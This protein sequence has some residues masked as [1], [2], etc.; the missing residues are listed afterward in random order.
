MG[1][2][3]WSQLVYT[4]FCE[5]EKGGKKQREEVV[6]ALKPLYFARSLSFDYETWRY[7]VVHAEEQVRNQALAFLSQRPY[8]LGLSLVARR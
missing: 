6:E 2:M 4:L 1:V 3:L 5:F 8:L 7:S